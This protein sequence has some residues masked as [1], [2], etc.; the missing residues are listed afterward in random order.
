MYRTIDKIKKFIKFFLQRA[1]G[2]FAI[3][4]IP[5]DCKFIKFDNTFW[6]YYDE[7]PSFNNGFIFHNYKTQLEHL[8]PD[9][10]EICFSSRAPIKKKLIAITKVFSFQF[11]SRPIIFN[12]QLFLLNASGQKIITEVYNYKFQLTKIFNYPIFK[13]IGNYH[14]ALDLSKFTLHD[15]DYSFFSAGK[16]IKYNASNKPIFFV[17]KDGRRDDVWFHREIKKLS[18][19][20]DYCCTHLIKKGNQ[21]FFIIRSRSVVT[22]DY[23][24][25]VDFLQKKVNTYSY[26]SRIS[27]FCIYRDIIFIYSKS[28]NNS[29]GFYTF[30]YISGRA[31]FLRR[32]YD[33]H[34]IFVRNKI[35]IDS[36]PRFLPIISF[37]VFLS[38]PLIKI[39]HKPT[40][41]S[42]YRTDFHPRFEK[43]T[44][45]IFFDSSRYGKRV[46]GF[47]DL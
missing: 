24:C 19:G 5:A 20:N 13:V 29:W 23:L 37:G 32:G 26:F 14:I 43:N 35:Y 15:P 47:L 6:G 31:K 33:G 12:N 7:V 34:P 36:Y 45:S 2:I 11:G 16:L 10:V 22:K 39:R 17:L 21:L 8:P 41:G 18:L 27:H 46:C 44:K 9:E 38:K 30:N 1:F 4:K 25:I 42:K 28:R 40:F 3:E